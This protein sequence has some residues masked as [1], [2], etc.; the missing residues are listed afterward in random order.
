[1]KNVLIIS[2]IV[3]IL[4]F[5]SS[6]II[7]TVNQE[8]SSSLLNIWSRWD[9]LSYLNIAENGYQN[10]DENKFLIAFFPFY[11]LLIKLFTFVFR[12]Y[13]LSALI[14]S[15]LSYIVASLFLYK[16]VLK[17][18]H[19]KTALRAVFYLA[20]FPTAYF[21]HAGYTE[22]LFLVLLLSSFYYARQGRWL[23]ASLLGMFASFTRING[24]ILLPA[25]FVEYLLQRKFKIKDIKADI[26]WLGIV[27]V[28]FLSYLFINYR[29]FGNAFQFLSFMKDNW[30]KSASWPWTGFLGALEGL[31]WRSLSDR[32][33]VSGAEIFFTAI[34][35]FLIILFF[36]KIRLS[37][38]VY[39]ILSLL[40]I[41]STS[42]WLSIPRYLLS[43]F[44][45]FIALAIIGRKPKFNYLITI[46]SLM[47]YTIFLTFF[48]QGDWAF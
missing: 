21:L 14:I 11:P 17:D 12:D 15:N 35:I 20:I 24:I 25:L 43:I 32:F 13:R 1:M 40:L 39:A 42:F 47:F 26:L 46:A 27:P 38:G 33:M 45:I 7:F 22:S 48:I 37:Y 31:Q 8:T 28:G 30:Q 9:G 2:L 23:S 29:V 3:I 6:F 4:T 36:K 18:F 44:P 19:E 5:L 41:T 10:I 34:G 16:L